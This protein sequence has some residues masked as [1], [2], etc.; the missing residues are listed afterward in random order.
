MVATAGSRV[1]AGTYGWRAAVIER[2]R[3]AAGTGRGGSGGGRQRPARG[4][5]GPL[6]IRGGA[7]RRR[8]RWRRATAAGAVCG[9]VGRCCSAGGP[10]RG[11]CPPRRGRAAGTP[12]GRHSGD[13][14]TKRYGGDGR[15]YR[16][17]RSA[18]DS[19]RG[20]CRPK[21]C[22]PLPCVVTVAT[23]PHR[24]PA[25]HLPWPCRPPPPHQPSSALRAPR[26][27][28]RQT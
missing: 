10:T 26:D 4:R 22:R 5:R 11:S 3:P 14:R 18:G 7:P 27:R 21:P 17:G 20:S 19:R 9:S 24:A 2:Q 16:R 25:G 1:R 13:G 8:C 23:S 28:E 12:G 6:S 15:R